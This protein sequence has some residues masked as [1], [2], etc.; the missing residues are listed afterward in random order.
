MLESL[1]FVA[2]EGVSCP[3][4]EE[5]VRGICEMVLAEEG[6][7]R[8]CFVSVTLVGEEHIRDI[9]HTWRG[10]DRPTDVV[11]LEC[12]RPDDPDLAA[13][14]PCELGDVVLAPS[15]IERQALRL[16]TTYPN[17]FRLLLVHGLLH[18]LG[19]DHIEEEDARVMEEREDQL[20]SLACGTEALGHVTTTRHDEDDAS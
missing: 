1:D 15:Y 9:N 7:S 20:V 14:E 10:V 19:Y 4:D 12:E 5:E 6:V 13:G 16:G 11:S 17:E 3:L 8:P 18:L 2:D